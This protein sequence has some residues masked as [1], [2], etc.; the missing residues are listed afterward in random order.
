MHCCGAGWDEAE[1]GRGWKAG[2]SGQVAIGVQRKTSGCKSFHLKTGTVWGQ[3][4]RYSVKGACLAMQPPRFN[5]WHPNG[6]PPS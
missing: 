1:S 6:V 4:D 2:L 5:S 3:R